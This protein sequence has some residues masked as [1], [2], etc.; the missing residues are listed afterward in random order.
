MIN[1]KAEASKR[2]DEIVDDL[3]QM[4]AIKSI[5]DEETISENAP[6]GANIRKALDRFIE[7]A[8]RDGFTYK[9]V[10]GHAGYI[11]YGEG[12]DL[13]G[14]LGHLDVVPLGEGWNF[15][16]LACT[17][18]EGYLFGRGTSD[19]KGPSLA[20][21]HAI[22]LLKDNDV[23]LNRRVRLIVG[24]DEETGFRCVEYYK[25]HEEIPSYGFTPDA[26]FPVIYGEKGIIQLFLNSEQDSII[27]QMNGGE[28]GNVVIGQA[29]ATIK[30][31]I[32][33]VEFNEFLASNNLK[34]SIEGNTYFVEGKPAHA[35]EPHEG[36]NAGVY[37]LEFISK[38][39]D[40]AYATNLYNLLLSYTGSGLGIDYE[41]QYMGPLTMNVGVIRIANN[42]QSVLIDIRYPDGLEASDVFAKIEAKIVPLNIT[43][44]ID[45]DKDKVFLDPNGE[46][47]KILESVY[48]E[49]TGDYDSPLIT[50]GGGTYAKALDNHVAYGMEFPKEV[51]PSIVGDIHQA[52]E[53]V[54][55][56]ALVNGTAIYA[57]AIVKLCNM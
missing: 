28:V 50:M 22:K 39:Y 30:G 10:D 55:I 26:N 41:G 54:S 9:D 15:D 20:A 18:E 27:E 3:K 29:N 8:E 4:V 32:K 48:R 36:V 13:V 19:D 25:E 57:H 53:A 16:P 6:Y 24:C 31:D 52:D 7:M 11:E 40:D 42:K 1:Y 47:I 45:T 51:K 5:Y 56:E 35:M 14:V 23:K 49:E 21:Y 46:M 37:L 33:A 34:G 2:K 12:D 44:D 38:N 17:E 43:M